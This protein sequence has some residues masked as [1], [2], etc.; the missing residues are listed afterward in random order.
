VNEI[1]EKVSL[2]TS[3]LMNGP[4]IL[5]KVKNDPKLKEQEK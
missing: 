3:I 2:L 4:Q 5:Q 1:N